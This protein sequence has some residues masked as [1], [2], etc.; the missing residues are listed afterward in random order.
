MHNIDHF[1]I[2]ANDLDR[3]SEYFITITGL[4]LATGGSHPDLGTRNKLIATTTD[5]Y[6]ELIAPD[7]ALNATSDLREAIEQIEDPVLH[8]VIA[9]GSLE[10]FPQ[11]VDAYQRAGVPA[12]V[13]PL[14]RETPS[15][16]ILRWHLLMPAARNEFGIFAPL[17][18]DWGLTPHPSQTLP[19]AACT[20]VDCHAGHPEPE[21]IRALWHEIGFDLPLAE[22]AEPHLSIRLDTPRGRVQL[23]SA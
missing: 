19:S 9:L 21:R 23:R 2:A 14:S 4:P 8:R 15:G 6:L 17:F 11:I 22:A 18:I 3:L 1:M 20:L 16:D 7:P 5:V 13:R 10:R 12:V